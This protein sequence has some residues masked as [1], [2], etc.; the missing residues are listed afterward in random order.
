MYQ[1]AILPLEVW[2]NRL[3][4]MNLIH[5]FCMWA[6]GYRSQ[7]VSSYFHTEE[8]FLFNITR[9]LTICRNIIGKKLFI[10]NY[11]KFS[12][13]QATTTTGFIRTFLT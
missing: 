2:L 8:Q 6:P 10:S 9:E 1:I 12:K 11:S 13:T 4:Q 5:Y 7:I 3:K